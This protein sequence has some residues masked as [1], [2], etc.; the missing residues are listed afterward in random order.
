MIILFKIVLSNNSAM[1]FKNT[2]YF[3]KSK[4]LFKIELS[5]SL[6]QIKGFYSNKGSF[7]SDDLIGETIC[8]GFYR[9][10]KHAELSMLC[11]EVSTSILLKEHTE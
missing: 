3:V 11:S 6:Y 2:F 9:F 5:D 1:D 10:L 4:F 7:S 8:R